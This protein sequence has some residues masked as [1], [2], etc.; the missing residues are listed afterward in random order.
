[1][2]S[3]AETEKVMY[4]TWLGISLVYWEVV[5]VMLRGSIMHEG[6]SF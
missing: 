3:D 6:V 5:D 2:I 1:M 4:D